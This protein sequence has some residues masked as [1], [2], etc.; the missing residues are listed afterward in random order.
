MFPRKYAREMTHGNTVSVLR[1]GDEFFPTLLKQIRAAKYEV[2][3]ETFILAEDRVGVDLRKAL[4]AAA[5][6]GVFVAVTVDSWGS[7]Y[8]KEPYIK[9]LTEANVV[10]QI[11][12]PQ[13]SMLSFRPKIFRRLHRKLAVID[14]AIAH[15]GGINLC[16][17]HLISIGAMGKRDYSV[18]LT[19]PVVDHVRELC[20][21]YLQEPPPALPD[22]ISTEASSAALKQFSGCDVAFLHR[23]NLVNKRDIE[24]AYVLGIKSAEKRIVLANAYFFP[25]IRLLRALR[26]ADQRGVDVKIIIQGNPDIPFALPAARCLYRY[27]ASANIQI[28]E[29]TERPLHGK[30][31][32]IDDQWSTVGS[33]NL[34][35]WSLAMNLEANVFIKSREVNQ[36]LT[37]CLLDLEKHSRPADQEIVKKQSA[38]TQFKYKLYYYVLK[39]VPF[40]VRWIPNPRPYIVEYRKRMDDR[41]LHTHGLNRYKII[42]KPKLRLLKKLM[43]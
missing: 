17:E 36:A 16:E 22:N 41:K 7:F 27:L 37:E 34:D 35:P 19:G 42:H 11:Y 5:Q 2:I 24:S 6:R 23:D 30:V 15:V 25:S 26:N 18:E 8:L 40:L 1:D 4:I 38:L 9:E 13:P 31:A 33:S 14:G 3:I 28:Y 29:Y 10:F 21:S 20:V 32:I 39:I 43:H 12:D